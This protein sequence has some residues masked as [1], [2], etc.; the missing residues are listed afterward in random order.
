[1]SFI[2]DKFNQMVAEHNGKKWEVVDAT[3]PNQCF[4]LAVGFLDYLAL[5]RSF[6][7]LYAYQ[8]YTSPTALT[9]L[10]FEI[11]PNG[12]IAVPKKGDI[13]VWSSAYGPAGHVAVSNGVGNVW[14]FEV[15]SQNDPIGSVCLIR[16]YSY[17]KVL[18]WLRPKTTGPTPIL[19]TVKQL[20]AELAEAVANK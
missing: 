5:P 16:Q 13:V 7:H 11:I 1:M 12:P 19:K 3:N 18:G 14:N 4:D 20:T 9:K 6:Q 17:S 8:I 10:N 15:F 2:D